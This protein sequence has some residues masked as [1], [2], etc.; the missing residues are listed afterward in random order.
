MSVYKLLCAYL[1]IIN[2]ATIILFGVDKLKAMT[3]KWRIEEKTLW[4]FSFL[5]G[6]IGA[7]LAIILFNHKIKDKKFMS[8][9][10]VITIVWIIGIIVFL[11]KF[12]I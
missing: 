9:F 4:L 1:L 8:I 10:I 7:W 3:K 6:I 2:V 12:Y 11:S 5:G